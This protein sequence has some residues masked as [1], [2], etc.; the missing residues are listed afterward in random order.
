[1]DVDEGVRNCLI[2][3]NFFSSGLIGVSFSSDPD[4]RAQVESIKRGLRVK[5]WNL[6]HLKHR[7]FCVKDLLTVYKS[8]I[9]PAHVTVAAFTTLYSVFCILYFKRSPMYTVQSQGERALQ[10]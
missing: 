9:L 6:H 8:I 1:M 10:Y 3:A 4:M 2:A 7:G 5:K